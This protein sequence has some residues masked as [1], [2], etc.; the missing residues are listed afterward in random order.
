[1]KTCWLHS[2]IALCIVCLQGAHASELVVKPSERLALIKQRGT[3]LVGVK[4]DYPPFGTLS[5]AGQPEGFEHDLAA[6]VAKRLG[7]ALTKVSV[8][9]ANRFQRLEEG[10]VDVLIATTGDTVERRRIVT[11]VEP[12][13]YASGVT[14]FMRPDQSIADWGATRGQ[15]VCATQGSYFN[16]AM[17]ERF[18]LDLQI[19]N[20]ARDAKLAVKDQRCVGYLFDNT[21][22]QGDLLLPEWAG[23]KAPLPPQLVTP[24]A[25]AIS[26]SEEGTEFERFLGD[27][28]ADWHRTG[29][30]I[31]RERAWQLP[32]SSFLADMRTLW[33]S[34][35]SD[36]TLLCVRDADNQ[37]PAACRNR[38]FLNSTDTTGLARLGLWLKEKTSVDLNFIYDNYDRSRFLLGLG[39]TALL[40]VLCVL[41]SVMVGVASALVI[42]ARIPGVTLLARWFCNIGR[43]TPPLLVI[44]IFVFGLSSALMHTVG[45]SMAPIVVVV[46]CLSVYAGAS[47]TDSFLE[48]TKVVQARDPTYCLRLNNFKKILPL[49]SPSATAALVNICK[50]TMMASAVAVPELLSAVTSIITEQGNVAV[51]MNTL[52][53]TFF[54]LIFLA[55]RFLG[56]V[57]RKLQK[58]KP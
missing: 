33:T 52:L 23:Y 16:R 8:T 3:L 31:E 28:L 14:L 24:W 27:T 36:G 35:G 42:S 32:P 38:I 54:V 17:A 41:G 49:A 39:T 30:L 13:Y 47:V 25:V 58:V 26:R 5:R 7:V 20:N 18:L 34:V 19:F 55:T 40:M 48:A 45:L 11:M 50:A 21:A 43:M 12:N 57:D 56:W 51:M 4:T 9:G 1:M 53:F 10:T 46:A 29:F 22:I 2:V 15:K 44:Y 6:D 37:W